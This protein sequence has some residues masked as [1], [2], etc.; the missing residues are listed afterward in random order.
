MQERIGQQDQPAPAAGEQPDSEPMGFVIRA[1]PVPPA[2]TRVWA[3]LWAAGPDEGPR[4]AAA[5]H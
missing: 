5:S 4:P 3:Y 1:R 2:S